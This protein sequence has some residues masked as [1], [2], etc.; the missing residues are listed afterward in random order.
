M[1]SP[2]LCLSAGKSICGKCSHPVQMVR[3]EGKR[4]AVDPE[5]IAVV[6]SGRLGEAVPAR[7][8]MT[9]RRIHAELCEGYRIADSKAKIRR[10]MAEFTRRQAKRPG[11]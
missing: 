8:T 6:P 3:V 10:E 9:G 11:L 2:T 4:V 1:G 7:A 5:V